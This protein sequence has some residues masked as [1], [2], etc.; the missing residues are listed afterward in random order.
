MGCVFEEQGGGE[1]KPPQ[2]VVS[3]GGGRDRIGGDVDAVYDGRGNDS[4]TPGTGHPGTIRWPGRRGS[5]SCAVD[6][7]DLPQVVRPSN[8]VSN[9]ALGC[10]NDALGCLRERNLEAGRVWKQS[11]VEVWM[12]KHPNRGPGAVPTDS[13]GCQVRWPVSKAKLWTSVLSDLC[14]RPIPRAWDWMFDDLRIHNP[15]VARFEPCRPHSRRCRRPSSP[16]QAAD[17]PPVE[18]QAAHD[19]IDSV[20]ERYP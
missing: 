3:G 1:I 8:E 9:D 2:D 4:S 19:L 6:T 15:L 5:D 10:L 16:S 17:R 12:R 14:S 13:T 20:R 11:A 7:E 18:R